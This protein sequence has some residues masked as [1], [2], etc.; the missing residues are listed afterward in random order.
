MVDD[1]SFTETP[2]NA[3]SISEAV[4]GGWW[5]GYLTY[6]GDGYDYTFKPLTQMAANPYSFEAVLSNDG[7]APQNTMLHVG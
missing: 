1:V 4:H 5:E 3:M 6:G 2:D 7:I